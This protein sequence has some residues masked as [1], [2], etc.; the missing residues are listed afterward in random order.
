MSEKNTLWNGAA[1]AGL[2]LGG[3]SILY[4]CY[5]GLVGGV[6]LDITKPLANGLMGVLNMLIWIAKFV[7]CIYLMRMF[8]LKY[9]ASDPDI[10]NRDVRRF[11]KITALLS[12]LVYSAFYMAY[13]L[14][15]KPD[16]F[17][18]TMS[19]ML[20]E[21]SN[22]PGF[23]SANIEA[24]EAMLPQMPTYTF[25][26]NLLYCFLFGVIVSSILSRNIPPRNPFVDTR[27]N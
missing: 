17:N 20:A 4:I 6:S 11:G 25:F 15:I 2:V 7:G 1:K 26:I 22:T 13:M 5:T 12:S 18:E 8:L 14:F 19:N 16:L 23:S 24:I 9:A 10:T 3:V 27:S 21:M